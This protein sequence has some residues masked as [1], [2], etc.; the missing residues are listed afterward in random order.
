MTKTWG[1]IV[2]IT[3][4]VLTLSTLVHALTVVEQNK[5]IDAQKLEIDTLYKDISTLYKDVG[6]LYKLTEKLSL[7]MEAQQNLLETTID[8]CKMR[9]STTVEAQPTSRH[10]IQIRPLAKAKSR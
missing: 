9:K 3:V 8:M 5:R 7:N 1:W 6:T 4:A 10:I 2:T